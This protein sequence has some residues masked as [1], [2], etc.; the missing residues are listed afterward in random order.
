MRKNIVLIGMPGSG[1]TTIGSILARKM[2][3]NFIDMDEFIESHEKRS[4]KDM[5]AEGEKIFRDAETKSSKLLCKL[6]ST[7]IATGG[8][9]VTKKENM[10][11]LQVNS[12]IVFLNRPIEN[13]ANDIKMQTRPLLAKG[14]EALYKIYHDRIHLYKKYGQIEIENIDHIDRVVENIM[15]RVKEK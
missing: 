10:D 5:F 14:V 6:N 7:V 15:I 13:I 1:K 2:G 4:I 8:G 3:M 9:I 12:I 11:Y